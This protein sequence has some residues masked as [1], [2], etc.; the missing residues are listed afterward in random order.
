[1]KTWTV[2]CSYAGYYASTVVVSAESVDE[3]LEKAIEK[4][5]NDSGW[6]ALDDCSRTFIDAVAE[7]EG[8]DP[9]DGPRST[10]PVPERFTERREGPVVTVF[11]NGGNVQDV[12]IERGHACVQ[13]RD[14][15][16]DEDDRTGLVDGNGDRY[17]LAEYGTCCPQRSST[18][19]PYL[20]LSTAHVS[21]A[22]MDWLNGPR[23]GSGLTI[24]PYEYGAFVSVPGNQGL[25]ADTECPEDLK[26]VLEYARENGCDV[27]RFDADGRTVDGLPQHDW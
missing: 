14:Y 13:I 20:D 6:K 23:A 4:A 21:R 26:T 3:A 27:V 19:Y 10:I 16:L 11:V 8:V 1:M 15:D 12:R 24:A 18:I 17:V 22:T 5:N 2:Q 9:W 25:V 7:G